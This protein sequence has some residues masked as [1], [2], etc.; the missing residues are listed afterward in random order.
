MID[1]DIRLAAMAD[2]TVHGLSVVETANATAVPEAKWLTIAET[3]KEEGKQAVAE[4]E[5]AAT[6]SDVPATSAVFW[7][8]PARRLSDTRR[9]TTSTSS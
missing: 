8:R 9:T 5:R 7:E 1:R 6:D 3:L 4:I 2:A